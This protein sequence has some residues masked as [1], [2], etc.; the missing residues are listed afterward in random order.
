MSEALN[1][2]TLQTGGVIGYSRRPASFRVGYM[3][4]TGFG[5]IL[6]ENETASLWDHPDGQSADQVQQSFWYGTGPGRR[7]AT[8]ILAWLPKQALVFRVIDFLTDLDLGHIMVD[9]LTTY[10]FAREFDR[11]FGHALRQSPESS[12]LG[13]MSEVITTN[14]RQPLAIPATNRE[15]LDSFC[16]PKTRWESIGAIFVALGSAAFSIP[17]HEPLYREL[18]P[19][20]TSKKSFACTMLECADACCMLSDEV[21]SHSSLWQVRLLN[22]IVGLQSV[23]GKLNILLTVFATLYGKREVQC[24]CVN[25]LAMSL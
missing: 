21:S 17:L 1:P 5:A 9:P 18:V 14:T 7:F 6:R 11:E 24:R 16:G 4:S 22:D 2:L 19:E 15:W 10:H 8:S 13:K 20:G 12:A 23:L 25:R 3:G